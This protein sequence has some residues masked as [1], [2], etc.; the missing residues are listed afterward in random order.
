VGVPISKK[1]NQTIE[2]AVSKETPR[3][4]RH[5]IARE[6]PF[7]GRF[8]L[9]VDADVAFLSRTHPIV[10]GLASYTL[11]TALDEVQALGEKAI[12]RRCGV[13]KT[14]D[15]QEKTTVLAVRVRYHLNVKKRNEADTHPLLAEEVLTVAFNGPPNDPGWLADED[16]KHLLDITPTGN[17][18]ASLVK[19]QLGHLIKSLEDLRPSLDTFATSRAHELKQAHTRVRRSAKMTGTVNVVPVDRVDILGCFILL[20]DAN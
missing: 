17:L 7:L 5:A 1:P 4:L 9:P 3:A 14:A 8:N 6:K 19:Q 2:V 10:E 12:A 13:T 20:P 16:S 11:D 18:P 15:V